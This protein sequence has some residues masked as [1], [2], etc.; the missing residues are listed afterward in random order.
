MR[1]DG[2]WCSGE[3]PLRRGI[4]NYFQHLFSKSRRWWISVEREVFKQ[5]GE[6]DSRGFKKPFGGEENLDHFRRVGKG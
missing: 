6:E 2:S 3:A 1:F 5:L 4:Q